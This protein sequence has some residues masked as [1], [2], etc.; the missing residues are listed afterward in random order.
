M[1]SATSRIPGPPFLLSL[2]SIVVGCLIGILL[3][4]DNPN[5][6]DD[7]QWAGVVFS[8]GIVVG[9]LW[10]AA[11]L[12]AALM[13]PV[14]LLLFGLVYWLLLDLMQAL[15][16]PEVA[17]MDAVR[18][19]FLAVGLFAVG[20]LVAAQGRAT[21]LPAFMMRA[22]AVGLSGK[23]LFQLGLIAF[24]LSFLRFAIPA[25][26]NLDQIY[27]ALFSDR[28][29]APWSR[30]A[31]GGWDAFLDH[32]SYF[33][34]L[35]PALTV[36]LYRAEGRF[37]W[38][39]LLLAAMAVIIGLLLA[40]GGGRRVVGS[41]ALS[42]GVILVLTSRAKWRSIILLVLFGLPALLMYMQYILFTRSAGIS[43][44]G[45]IPY[46][47][48][49]TRGIAV[50]DNINRLAQLIEIIPNSVPH[51]WFDWVI[52]ILV[53]PIPRILWP[54][55]PD[56][57]GFDLATHLGMENVSLTSSVVGESYMAF[58]L[59]GCMVIGLVYGHLAKRLTSLFDYLAQPGA[60]LMYVLG[61]MALFVGLRSAV[62]VLLISYSILA[63]IVLVS[64][65]VDRPGRRG[66][67]R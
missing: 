52:W 45:D 34:Y 36:L 13:H 65:F 33:G 56:D 44:S 20:L 12:P 42:A 49:I 64:I 9:P 21:R 5:V 28:F 27:G 58:G 30:G 35:L 6:P 40:Q 60:A 10:V 41:L 7:L 14:S 1:T 17:D 47:T 23:V 43:E 2:S 11:R 61:M 37:T 18:L 3:I 39:T 32:I 63:W 24:V 25:E 59:M 55:K 26:F 54:D 67:R 62:E 66:A 48:L 8:I 38:R 22:A 19:A 15:Y 16:L 50:D 53:R 57:F 46:Q 31:Y 29:S 4:P 51:V